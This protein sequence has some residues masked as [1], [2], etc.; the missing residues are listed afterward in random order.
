MI[1]GVVT[2]AG[3]LMV[4][5]KLNILHLK[6]VCGK[7]VF[8]RSV[9]EECVTAG[10]RRGYSDAYTLRSFLAQNYWYPEGSIVI[11]AHLSSANLDLGEKEAIA[12]A[13]SHNAM[14]LMD[15]E[16]GRHVARKNGL[17][18]HGSLWVLIKSYR[19]G[20]ITEDQLL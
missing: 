12:L 3:P 19:R 16:R 4:F 10:I 18:V 2:N 13:L 11:P 14:L 1:H 20:L 5:A 7:P 15:E 8:P 17:S 9:W 6:E